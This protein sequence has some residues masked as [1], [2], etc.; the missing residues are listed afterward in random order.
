MKQWDKTNKFQ[1]HL[2]NMSYHVPL[3]LLLNHEEYNT[4]LLPAFVDT[5]QSTK[6]KFLLRF[7]PLFIEDVKV[8]KRNQD[9][10][11]GLVV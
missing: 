6:Q 2:R 10:T 7:S 11:L 3:I 4:I 8:L 1:K 5:N 9:W